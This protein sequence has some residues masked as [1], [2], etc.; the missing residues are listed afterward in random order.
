MNY[1]AHCLIGELA[2]GE[3]DLTPAL[4]AG[5]FLG[6]FVKGPVPTD[7]PKELALGVRLHRRVDAYSNRQPD[8]R[9]ST[10]RF[11]PELRR[12]A[13]ILVDILCDH[14]LSR[15]WD[16]FHPAALPD[17]TE[18]VYRH[19]DDHSRWLPARG[20]QFLDYARERDLLLRYGDWSVTA[21]SM[22]S[23]TRRLG[24]SELDPLLAAA[25]PPMLDAL[26]ADFRRYFPDILRHARTWVA[27]ERGGIVS[28]QS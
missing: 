7:M 4:V 5:G 1:L 16:E 27:G 22:R 19:L 8:I 2:A 10:D 24:R 15:R 6:D 26:E 13:P 18:D 3:A 23:I 12:I 14:L 25:I 20:R 28:R 11:P 9:Q 21:A 17:F